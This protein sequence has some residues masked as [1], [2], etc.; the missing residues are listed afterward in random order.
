[1]AST[2]EPSPY[3]SSRRR[4]DSEFNLREWT[5][6][7]RISRENTNSRRYSGSYMRSFRED[8]RSFRSNITISS[9]ASSPG[10][11]LKDE[12]DPSTY[13][14]T[15]ALKALQARAGFNSWECLSPDGF[16]LNSKWNE[17]E[18]YICNP[19]SGEVPMEC[20]SAKTL[21]GRS[22]RNS[23]NRITMSAPLVYSSRQIQTKPSTY[24]QEVVALQLPISEKKKEGMTRDVGTQSTPPYLS[25]SSPSP[26][27]T[28]SII[29]RSKNRAADSPNSNAKTK[30]EEEVEVKD[31]ETWETKETEREKNEWRR[32]KEQLCKQGGCFSWILKK[33][34]KG[35]HLLDKIVIAAFVHLKFNIPFF[36]FALLII[37][38]M[39]LLL[40]HLPVLICNLRLSPKDLCYPRHCVAKGSLRK[41]LF[42]LRSRYV[43]F[44]IGSMHGSCLGGL[45]ML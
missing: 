36:S 20:L 12:I 10:Y 3:S 7:A 28:P 18:R 24:T 29:E 9:T 43:P 8:T 38:P 35:Q 26:A 32:E 41:I 22:F 33:K 39:R 11:P 16:A 37:I 23:T 4:D 34:K 6:K 44:A 45:I 1:M 40:F 21:S 5:L 17:A 42:N 19:L 14:F 13:S 2:A 30:S 25:S 31:K 15:T 27:S